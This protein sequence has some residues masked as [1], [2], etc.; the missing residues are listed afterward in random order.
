MRIGKGIVA[1]L[2]VI[3]TVSVNADGKFGNVAIN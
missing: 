2:A 1:A 3:V